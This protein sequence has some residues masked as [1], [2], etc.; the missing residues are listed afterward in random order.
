[1]FEEN[2]KN[3]VMGFIKLVLAVLFTFS[4]NGAI[5]TRAGIGFLIDLIGSNLV[6]IFLGILFWVG[7]F[8][9][10]FYFISLIS[11]LYKEFRKQFKNEEETVEEK[12][13]TPAPD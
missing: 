2:I 11:L 3:L 13:K 10:I 4:V 5:K 1:M 6:L 12:I 8:F 7:V 9:S